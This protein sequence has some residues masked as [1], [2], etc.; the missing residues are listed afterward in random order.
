MKVFLFKTS[1]YDPAEQGKEIEINTLEELLNVLDN[2]KSNE[3]V[4]SRTS[5]HVKDMDFILE[6]VDDYRE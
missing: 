1:D 2:S 3:L 6:D 4:I 5:Y